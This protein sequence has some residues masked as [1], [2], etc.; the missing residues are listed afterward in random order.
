MTWGSGVQA[1]GPGAL[2]GKAVRGYRL[3][4]RVRGKVQKVKPW[5]A[6]R[7]HMNTCNRTESAGGSHSQHYCVQSIPHGNI[8]ALEV[9]DAGRITAIAALSLINFHG[10]LKKTGT[11]PNVSSLTSLFTNHELTLGSVR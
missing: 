1:P 10:L 4:E 7:R 8:S 9:V 5:E 3:L 11:E 6:T 2:I